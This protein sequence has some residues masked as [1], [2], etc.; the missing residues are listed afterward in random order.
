MLQQTINPRAKHISASKRASDIEEQYF[1]DPKREEVLEFAES[2]AITNLEDVAESVIE[3]EYTDE[4][5]LE[6][7]D[8]VEDA[9]MPPEEIVELPGGD[10]LSTLNRY[11]VDSDDPQ[12]EEAIEMN[13]VASLYKD[14]LKDLR[15][16]KDKRGL[17]ILVDFYNFGEEM[18]DHDYSEALKIMEAV[19]EK[20]K[21]LGLEKEFD[22]LL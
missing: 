19:E 5:G 20:V 14:V 11:V 12:L 4:S 18:I 3:E 10:E 6:I 9:P 8:Q 13:R 15:K 16:I 1:Q 2:G 22:K 17:E 7:M 21:Q